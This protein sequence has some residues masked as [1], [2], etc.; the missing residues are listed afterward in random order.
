M[1]FENFKKFEYWES[2][3][4]SIK[5]KIIKFTSFKIYQNWE[6]R[7]TVGH[8]ATIQREPEIRR[9]LN[10]GKAKPRL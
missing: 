10:F 4:I 8:T 5:T 6:F 3:E 2:Q 7:F 9:P 1:V